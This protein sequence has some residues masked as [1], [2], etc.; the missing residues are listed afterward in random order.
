[1]VKITVPLP[2]L[3]EQHRIVAKVDGLMVLCHRLEESL[4]ARDYARRRMLEAVLH[5][6]LEPNVDSKAVA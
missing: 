5:N 6:A 3:A 1:M 4:T 2:P